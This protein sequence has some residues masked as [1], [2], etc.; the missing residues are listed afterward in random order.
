M[1]HLDVA[2]VRIFVV[3]AQSYSNQNSLA[4]ACSSARE[5][6][7]EQGCAERR[8]LV[9]GDGSG[10]SGESERGGEWRWISTYSASYSSSLVE[11]V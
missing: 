4:V 6:W 11:V 8:S 1:A 9:C 5:F 7:L 2:G 10:F 3:A